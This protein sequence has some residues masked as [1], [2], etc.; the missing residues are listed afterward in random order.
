MSRRGLALGFCLTMLLAACR[1]A[2][3]R[4]APVA[5]PGAG[6]ALADAGRAA[7]DGAVGAPGATP[8]DA[9]TATATAAAA[10]AGTADHSGQAP[11]HT[12]T[13]VFDH[14]AASFQAPACIEGA[15]NQAWRKR[16]AGHPERF[17]AQLE[18]ILP[19]LAHVAAEL[20]A[21]GLPAEYALIPIVESWYRPEAVGPGGPAGLW[22]LMPATARHHGVRIG[23]GYDGRFNPAEAT[24]AAL[25]YLEALNR[26]FDGDWRAVAMAYNAGEFRILRAFRANGGRKVSG[27]ERLPAG[28]AHTTYA[29]VAKL[30]ALA[31]LIAEPERQGLVL[32]GEAHFTPLRRV[33]LPEPLHGLE[34]A[35]AWLGADARRL[36]SL[37]PAFRAGRPV[38]AGAG[39]ALLVPD[40]ATVRE[41]LAAG[42]PDPSTL[43]P[44]PAPRQHEIRP[45]DTLS[46][47][48]AR[49]GVPLRQL[50]ALNGLDARSILR[51]GRLLQVD[52]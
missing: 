28:L 26:R 36:R 41:R 2:D 47:I 40:T 38:P 8:T 42:P 24:D 31:C 50:Y 6:A 1:P 48:A 4:P 49:Y 10:G 12:G 35:A 14:L 27:E 17:A 13:Q 29:Y 37:N 5:A 3:L 23:A 7:D 30:R 16:Y 52:P 22:Q 11:W 43:P 34:Q 32:P 39:R 46:A 9:G 33:D 20:Q 45:G 19:L 18:R 51:P 44:A 25:A 15:H 21:R